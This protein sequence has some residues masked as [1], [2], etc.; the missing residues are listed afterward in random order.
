LAACEALPAEDPTTGTTAL[1]VDCGS[2]TTVEDLSARPE[3]ITPDRNGLFD[4][5]RIAATIVVHG[6]SP[7]AVLSAL[8][9]SYEL[10]WR[11]SVRQLP[12]RGARSSV[13]RSWSDVLDLATV[14]ASAASADLPI[15]VAWDGLDDRRLRVPD[16]TYQIAAEAELFLRP[17]NVP[18]RARVSRSE[19]ATETVVVASEPDEREAALLEAAALRDRIGF[20]PAEAASIDPTVFDGPYLFESAAPEDLRELSTTL[21]R[22]AGTTVEELF[23]RSRAAMAADPEI[24]LPPSAEALAAWQRLF[25]ESGAR[26]EVEW[27]P[28]GTPRRIAGLD[29]GIQAGDSEAIAEQYLLRFGDDLGA[30]LGLA[31]G[32]SWTAD[33]TNSTDDGAFS[34]VV[35]KHVVPASIGTGGPPNSD[36]PPPDDGNPPSLP[37]A[38]DQLALHVRHG[39]LP[40]GRGRALAVTAAWNRL[41]E[42]VVVNVGAAQAESAALAAIGLDSGSLTRLDGPRVRFPEPG[43]QLV[44]YALTLSQ[45]D[46]VRMVLVD[47]VTGE[48]TRVE[49]GMVRSRMIHRFHPLS[50]PDDSP[51]GPPWNGYAGHSHPAHCAGLP[52]A[53]VTGA[54]GRLT[55]TDATGA[56]DD[57]A[58]DWSVNVGLDG[59]HFSRWAFM[60]ENGALYP[61]MLYG[62][63]SPGPRLVLPTGPVAAGVPLDEPAK[64]T[65][66]GMLFAHAGYVRDIFGRAGGST[67]W[68][69][70]NLTTEWAPRGKRR[71]TVAN[72]CIDDRWAALSEGPDTPTQWNALCDFDTHRCTVDEWYDFDEADSN[73]TC[74]TT[75]MQDGPD[76]KDCDPG[77]KEQTYYCDTTIGPAGSDGWCDWGG[78]GRLHTGGG[79]RDGCFNFVTRA[80]E[81]RQ[82]VGIDT[83][84]M[85]CEW[86]ADCPAEPLLGPVDW[87]EPYAVG[88]LAHELGHVMIDNGLWLGPLGSIHGG[89]DGTLSGFLSEAMPTAVG[90]VW[91]DDF[92][93]WDT[94]FVADPAALQARF[95]GDPVGGSNSCGGP[96]TPAETDDPR[97]SYLCEQTPY[98]CETDRCTIRRPDCDGATECAACRATNSLVRCLGPA[99]VA[100]EVVGIHGNGDW[101][102]ALLA[103]YS[104]LAGRR[105]GIDGLVSLLSDRI[106]GQTIVARGTN[107]VAGKLAR[108]AG[109]AACN[110]RARNQ[111][112]AAWRAM[113]D[114]ATPA[115]QRFIPRYD[116]H[117]SIWW[118]GQVGDSAQPWS[119]GSQS[120]AGML[121]DRVDWDPHVLYLVGGREYQVRLSDL[122]DGGTTLFLGLHLPSPGATDATGRHVFLMSVAGTGTTTYLPTD[123]GYYHFAVSRDPAGPA[124]AVAYE[125]AVT[126]VG[127]DHPDG[128]VESV[129]LPQH[130][131]S[132]PA[133]GVVQGADRDAYRVAVESWS[134]TVV[135]AQLR[136][137]RVPVGGPRA[138]LEAWDYGTGTRVA[139]C[140]FGSI[141]GGAACEVTL[142][143][144]RSAIYHLYVV[145]PGGTA[146][147]PYTLATSPDPSHPWPASAPCADWHLPTVAPPTRCTL[148]S[149]G[150][151]LAGAMHFG[152]ES[153]N[154]WFWGREG[155]RYSLRFWSVFSGASAS[156]HHPT[157]QG[158]SSDGTPLFRFDATWPAVSFEAPV[159]GWYRLHVVGPTGDLGATLPV[160]YAIRFAEGPIRMPDYPE[161]LDWAGGSTDGGCGP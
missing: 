137:S 36:L 19:V 64:R 30:L 9:F 44:E 56:F 156:L 147:V 2:T 149:T 115:Y 114:T 129:M 45:E 39:G 17:P 15:V 6:G 134:P 118:H 37:V 73:N 116:D 123:S 14:L 49:D 46:Q 16:G 8:G 155:R 143:P 142:S 52:Y 92:T 78:G 3:R 47:A 108:P 151:V 119:V 1:A 157:A 83:Y 10:E 63:A 12:V 158:T 48:A 33:G 139:S 117:P 98:T 66:D 112:F 161:I 24:L 27:S 84:V 160:P 4:E 71:C 21:V 140:S 29:D 141:L 20:R 144:A 105:G 51:Y 148:G 80:A 59:L 22:A 138:V 34:T 32:E 159:T 93:F 111:G 70:I 50:F 54:D 55:A 13:L 81:G 31:P 60:E 101:F 53:T 120:V 121:E 42:P 153:E 87:A 104:A 90:R 146:R 74:N 154:L 145:G 91:Y 113:S 23:E 89:G 28:A 130:T 43:V 65:L 102:T 82:C 76:R 79:L 77:T 72:D 7:A 133:S 126:M 94:R 62:F 18:A 99:G 131:G 68:G 128:L 35:F 85:R 122:V 38:G 88:V 136:A 26:L 107:S 40:Q 95:G 125:L 61:R 109:S 41:V 110:I 135:R 150:P 75:D 152:G 97:D 124:D 132:T 58:V 69:K 100:Y 25:V 67:R 106:D 103:R 11:L 57:S 96:L 5:T 86:P 127:D